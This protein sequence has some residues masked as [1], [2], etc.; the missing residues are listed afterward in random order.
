MLIPAASFKIAK[1]SPFP[2]V[3]AILFLQTPFENGLDHRILQL[4]LNIQTISS[5][6][7]TPT[8]LD[9][10]LNNSLECLAPR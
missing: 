10:S 2:Q 8:N 4:H 5:T 6:N 9:A 1:S 7:Y 3:G